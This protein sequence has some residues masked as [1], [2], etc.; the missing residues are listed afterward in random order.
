[1]S[2]FDTLLDA[3]GQNTL[4][5]RP[6]SVFSKWSSFMDGKELTESHE[7]VIAFRTEPAEDKLKP[8]VERYPKGWVR[9]VPLRGERQ[10]DDAGRPAMG[11]IVEGLAGNLEIGLLI[12]PAH[13][14]SMS[15]LIARTSYDSFR[16][17]VRPYK[18]FWEWDGKKPIFVR[19]WEIQTMIEIEYLPQNPR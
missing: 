6:E 9:V 2:N 11:V 15:N 16:I 3:L 5:L 1:M 14:G 12:E 4:H 8:V 17:A 18:H 13:L 10:L 19:N 7:L